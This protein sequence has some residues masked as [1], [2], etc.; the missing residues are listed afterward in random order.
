MFDIIQAFK[1][2]ANKVSDMQTAINGKAASEH[3]HSTDDI[4]SGTLPAERGGTGNATLKDSMN[5]LVNSLGTGTDTPTDEDYFISQYVNGGDATTTYHRRKLSKLWAYIKSKADLVYAASGHTHNLGSSF[6]ITEVSK[7][8]DSIA[9]HSYQSAANISMAAQSGYTAIGI[10][11]VKSTNHRIRP[12]SYYVNSNT[13][14]YAGFANSSASANQSAT[15][16]FLVLWA[17]NTI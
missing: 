14:L 3:N 10:I 2:I 9:A 11:G 6:K 8:T 12:T 1:D 7:T 15:V 16:T 13:Q 17:K 5:A 4:T